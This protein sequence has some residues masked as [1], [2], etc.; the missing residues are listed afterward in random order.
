MIF[1]VQDPSGFWPTGTECQIM[2]GSTGDIY[3]QNYAWFTTTI[4]SFITDPISKKSFPRYAENGK[5]F[6]YG[7]KQASMRLMN[8]SRLDTWEGWNKVEI[9][10]KENGAEFY[11][12]NKFSA[13]LWNIRFIP[14]DNPLQD[15][16]LTVGRICLQAEATE[17][18]FKNIEIKMD[19]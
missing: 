9:V 18:I 11:V 16:P 10:V 8:L 12:N 14:P 2:E 13:K 4:D 17:I 1:H 5:N 7:G 6:D 15:K 19:N 3:A